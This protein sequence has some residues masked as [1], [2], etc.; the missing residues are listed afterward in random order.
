MLKKGMSYIVMGFIIGIAVVF[1]TLVFFKGKFF[2]EGGLVETIKNTTNIS[3]PGIEIGGGDDQIPQAERLNQEDLSNLKL[4]NTLGKLSAT[5]TNE[6]ECKFKVPQSFKN[7]D[8]SIY[9]SSKNS[10]LEIFFKSKDSSRIPISQDAYSEEKIKFLPIQILNSQYITETISSD[11]YIKNSKL[12][13]PNLEPLDLFQEETGTIFILSKS[14]N[15]D[16]F[17]NKV[18]GIF[19]QISFVPNY[20][21]IFGPDDLSKDYENYKKHIS[22]IEDCKFEA[23]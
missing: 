11:F 13:L 1:I 4:I 18:L 17:S 15:E 7:S 22:Q 6:K 10:R 21:F 23:K 3:I 16:P 14:I 20:N 9:F 19:S 12:Y 5:I 2:G 8:N